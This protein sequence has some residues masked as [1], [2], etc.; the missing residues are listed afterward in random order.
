MHGLL[1]GKAVK[2]LLK[3]SGQTKDNFASDL[4]F[5]TPFGNGEKDMLKSGKMLHRYPG[6]Q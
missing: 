6:R 2:E 4:Q 5:C 3:E 1:M